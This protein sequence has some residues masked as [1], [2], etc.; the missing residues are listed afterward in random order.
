MGAIFAAPMAYLAA[1]ER[2]INRRTE[3]QSQE[4]VARHWERDH[5]HAITALE[6]ITAARRAIGEAEQAL[7]LAVATARSAGLTW[8]AIGQAAGMAQQ[9]AQ[10]RWGRR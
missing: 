10:E 2:L 8:E 5:L 4:R 7:S 6:Q 9:S 1:S 3:D